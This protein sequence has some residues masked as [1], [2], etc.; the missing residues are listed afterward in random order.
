MLQPYGWRNMTRSSDK[1]PTLFRS[2][3]M[4]DWMEYLTPHY[5]HWAYPPYT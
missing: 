3:G 1:L 5:Y 2:L 4:C